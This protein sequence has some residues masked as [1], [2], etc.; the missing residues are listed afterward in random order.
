MAIG[1]GFSVG[2]V[3]GEHGRILAPPARAMAYGFPSGRCTASVEVRPF[4]EERDRVT[5]WRVSEHFR[6][7]MDPASDARRVR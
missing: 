6:A 7:N 5:C 4:E 3:S 1:V 2:S